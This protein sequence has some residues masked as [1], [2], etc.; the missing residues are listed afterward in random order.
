MH[1]DTLIEVT[2]QPR[3]SPLAPIG[4][5]AQGAAATRLAHRLLQE[6]AD[7]LPRF[8]GVSGPG[9]LVILGEE[10]LL[11]WV[12]KVVYL[13]R[14]RQSPSLLLPT[15]LEPSVPLSLLERSISARY[16]GVAPC[17]LLLNP[18]SIIPLAEARPLARKSLIKWLEADL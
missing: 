12:D 8:S 18:L 2:W 1:G 14:D 5:A 9:L 11:P 3:S 13:G 4:V 6:P 16:A 10:E 15:N 7:V 17:A